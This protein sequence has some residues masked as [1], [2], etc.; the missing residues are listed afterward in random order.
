[1]SRELD[2][3]IAEKVF[4]RDRTS[5]RV[6]PMN[7]D[8]EPQYHWGYP[9][10]HDFAPFYST[11]IAAAMVVAMKFM[12]PPFSG[13]WVMELDED[14]PTVTWDAR[15]TNLKIEDDFVGRAASLPE[16]ICLAALATLEDRGIT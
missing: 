10:G 1:M 9:T 14:A 13:W 15:L 16:A 12:C 7:R 5:A 4:G 2:E 11:D 3:Q 6:D 8:G